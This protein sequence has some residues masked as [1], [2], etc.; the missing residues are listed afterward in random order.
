MDVV[1]L[2]GIEDGLHL[3][4]GAEVDHEVPVGAF[5]DETFRDLVMEDA[6]HGV[7][8]G[9]GAYAGIQFDEQVAA[10]HLD[11]GEVGGDVFLDEA[12]VEG[13]GDLDGLVVDEGKSDVLLS[14]LFQYVLQL[15]EGYGCFNG[16]ASFAVVGGFLGDG[17]VVMMAFEDA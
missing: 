7:H 6:E 5:L 12:Q 2:Y 15:R 4:D 13:V 3:L 16:L 9:V 11:E 17:H 1:N 14:L 8:Q 10:H